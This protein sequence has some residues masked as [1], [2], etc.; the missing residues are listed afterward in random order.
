ME[1]RQWPFLFC[2]DAAL[3]WTHQCSGLSYFCIGKENIHHSIT[4]SF[5]TGYTE[6]HSRETSICSY[7]FGNA[8]CG[9]HDKC[10]FSV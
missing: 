5:V 2:I 7:R 9:G 1:R 6:E 10:T 8:R 4:W 3:G